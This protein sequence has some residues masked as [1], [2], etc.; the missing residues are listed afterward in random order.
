ML[1]IGEKFNYCF[2]PTMTKSNPQFTVVTYK[3]VDYYYVDGR[4]REQL[5]PVDITYY[6][7]M[8]WITWCVKPVP[9]TI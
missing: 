4:Y 1:S 5:K 8:C 2:P 3:V 7:P 6:N 9:P